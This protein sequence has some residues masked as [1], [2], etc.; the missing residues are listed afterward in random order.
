MP[1]QGVSKND[2]LGTR[3]RMIVEF[4]HLCLHAAIQLKKL[5]QLGSLSVENWISNKSKIKFIF[6]FKAV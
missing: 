2:L 5:F 3:D 1:K 6:D 4:S